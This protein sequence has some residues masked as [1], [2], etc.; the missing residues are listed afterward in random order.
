M[1]T[2]ND[3]AFTSYG[4]F[5]MSYATILIPSSGILTAYTNPDDLSNALGLYLIVCAYLIST[6]FLRKAW[7]IDLCGYS[8]RV[9]V[10]DPHAVW[11]DQA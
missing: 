5:W 4:A 6:L 9:H 3:A 7:N 2:I 8:Q 11:R 1:L 10:H